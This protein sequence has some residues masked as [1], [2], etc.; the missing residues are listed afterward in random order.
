MPRTKKNPIENEYIPVDPEDMLELSSYEIEITS[1]MDMVK[2]FYG[3]NGINAI[4]NLVIQY[5]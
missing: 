3:L 5:E 4:K 1:L 2:K